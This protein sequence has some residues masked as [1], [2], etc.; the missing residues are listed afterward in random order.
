[1]LSTQPEVVVLVIMIV[2][3]VIDISV[4]GFF[5]MLPLQL[6]IVCMS[7]KCTV[8]HLLNTSDCWSAQCLPFVKASKSSCP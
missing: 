2:N 8:M 1:M 7:V 5:S 4:R 6:C 3:N